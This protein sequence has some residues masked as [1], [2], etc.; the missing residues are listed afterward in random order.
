MIL[1]ALAMSP[2]GACDCNSDASLV[3]LSVRPDSGPLA[4]GNTAVLV[5]SGFAD[6]LEVRFGDTQVRAEVLSASSAQV[7]VPAATTAGL[8]RVSLSQGADE[9]ALDDAYR[10]VDAPEIA[11]IDPD[12]GSVDGGTGFVLRGAGFVEGAQVFI[13]GREALDVQ[14]MNSETLSG[15]TPPGAEG[16]ADVE[17]RNPDT[18]HSIAMG[19]FTYIEPTLCMV[20]DMAPAFG[21]TDVGTG[22]T[23]SVA[24]DTAVDPSAISLRLQELGGDEIPATVTA[25][26]ERGITITPNRP[27]RFWA[28]YT[29]TVEAFDS[30][31]GHRC[32]AESSVFATVEPTAVPQPAAPS[33][34]RYLATSGDHIFAASGSPW[35]QRWSVPAGE[36]PRLEAE[37]PLPG[38][39]STL[40]VIGDRL[41]VGLGFD[42][43]AVFDI[44]DPTMPEAIGNVGTPGYVQGVAPFDAGAGE[45][46][47]AVADDA[48][49]VWLFNVTEPEAE[50]VLSSIPASVVDGLRLDQGY[51]M[52][53]ATQGDRLAIASN[54]HG[55]SLWDISD[56]AT[57]VRIT[58]QPARGAIIDLVFGP[59]GLYTAEQ[60]HI[61]LLDA[62]D[63]TPVAT[64]TY[65]FTQ[66]ERWT[67]ILLLGDTLWASALQVGARTFNAETLSST[68]THSLRG[69]TGDLTELPD[70][71]VVGG[72][73]VGIAVLDGDSPLLP[74]TPSR[75]T[76]RQAHVVGDDVFVASDLLGLVVGTWDAA[77][78]TISYDRSVPT[79]ASETADVAAA[80]VSAS[81]DQL[82]VGDGRLGVAVF[83]HTDGVPTFQ[84]GA[85]GLGD[86]SRA[87]SLRGDFVFECD[88]N[89]GLKVHDVSD[90]TAPTLL[91]STGFPAAV[92]NQC[93]DLTVIDDEL[94][95]AT[96]NGVVVI[97]VSDPAAPSLVG[98]VPL[99]SQDR[100][101]SLDTSDGYL[102]GTTSVRDFEG[103]NGV[104]QR[105]QVFD[106][107]DPASPERVFIS[108]PIEGARVV[109]VRQEL[110]FVGAFQQVQIYDLAD[111]SQPKLLGTVPVAGAV[112]HLHSNGDALFASTGDGGVQVIHTGLL[113]SR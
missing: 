33:P 60:S 24:W 79:P 61:R 113:P 52:D 82:I 67:G 10:Y 55:V 58:R 20:A 9:V 86:R 27:L 107:S 3:L 65:D 1:A 59:R 34:G 17:V 63:L 73:E 26:G 21:Q 11:E 104:I 7:V 89:A 85:E 32:P 15:R 66:V 100:V 102:V 2:L 38:T 92:R 71:R 4:G 51:S 95:L 75:G 19:L 42:G 62:A 72:S 57:P 93:Y 91:A 22:E 6:P 99:R 54:F 111:T 87:V 31:E 50:T 81:E 97:D 40:A 25:D 68:G 29:L 109:L 64:A 76:A 70:G 105:I 43:V 110:L 23:L 69:R 39:A 35:L 53:V 77:T 18:Q 106:V 94:Y 48:E 8:V 112:S 78:E 37:Y 101:I 16:P 41:Y 49:G 84:G 44:T 13:G 45:L 103:A 83:T 28:Q 46:G 108:E 36:A 90:P 47:L 12:R 80:V 56:P 98:E 96:Q 74:A 5:G 30:T 14:F 88:D